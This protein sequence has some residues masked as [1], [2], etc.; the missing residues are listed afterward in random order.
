MKTLTHPKQN[1]ISLLR[2]SDQKQMQSVCEVL[3]WSEEQYCL[4]QFDEYDNFINRLNP[5][6]PFIAQKLRYSPVFS[7]F[8]KNEWVKRTEKEFLIFALQSYSKLEVTVAGK[9]GLRTEYATVDDYDLHEYLFLHS[10][11]RLSQ[12]YD[13][14]KAYELVF[15]L[16]FDHE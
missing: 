5:D 2:K 3:N 4:H 14:L 1:D 7:G 9:I 11:I 16:V 13:F 12:N 8:W 6:S 15:N 10:A